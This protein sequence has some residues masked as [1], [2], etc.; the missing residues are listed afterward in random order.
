MALVLLQPSGIFDRYDKLGGVLHFARFAECS[1]T[2]P[3][4]LEA[5]GSTLEKIMG[6]SKIVPGCLDSLPWRPLTRQAFLGSWADAGTGV[7]RRRGDFTTARGRTL[8]DP[9]YEELNQLSLAGDSIVSGAAPIPDLWEGG[10]FAFAFSQPPYGLY[11]GT[12]G[13]I[14]EVFTAVFDLILPPDQSIEIRDWG[15][16]GLPDLCPDYFLPG[17]EWWGVF[18]FTLYAPQEKKVTV[19]VGS[20]T[21]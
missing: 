3:A 9:S 1:G 5:I 13:Q 19:V 8:V 14:Q 7:L 17:T 10:Q 21:D 4:L 16:P 6:A 20:A 2:D 11:R 18:L 15:S 12:P